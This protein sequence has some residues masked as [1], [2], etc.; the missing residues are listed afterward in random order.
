[1]KS[2]QLYILTLLIIF[3]LGINHVLAQNNYDANKYTTTEQD[4]E[5]LIYPNPAITDKFNVKSDQIIAC[6]EV[7]NVIGQRIAKV[8][9]STGLPYNMFV[10]LPECDEGIYMV[11][12]TFADKKVLIKKILIK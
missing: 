1:M 6:V 4:H 5:V 8:E 10:N 2:L 7:L 11:R 3:A 12:V 9:N